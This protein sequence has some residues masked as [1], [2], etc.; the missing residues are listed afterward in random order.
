MMT[1]L[2][3]LR[4][5]HASLAVIGAE[6]SRVVARDAPPASQDLYRLRMELASGLIRHLKTEDWILYPALLNSTDERIA[7]IAR[8][9]SASMGGLASEFKDYSELW[10]A[11]AIRKDWQGYQR[12][13]EKI[14]RALTL[15]MAREER[16]LYPLLDDEEQSAATKTA[17]GYRHLPN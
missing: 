14:L 4:E 9:F 7:L 16:D 8:A 17:E 10:G 3:K 13:T 12:E 5:E 6:L 1:D 2:Q 11:N 15:R